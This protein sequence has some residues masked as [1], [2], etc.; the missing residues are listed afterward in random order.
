MEILMAAFTAL[1]LGVENDKDSEPKAKPTPEQQAVAAL[2]KLGAKVHYRKRFYFEVPAKDKEK[3]IA[4]VSIE[5][6]WKGGDEGTRY[7]HVIRVAATE[8]ATDGHGPSLQVL[9]YRLIGHLIL[10]RMPNEGVREALESLA[11]M[12][13]FYQTRLQNPEALKLP[14]ATLTGRVGPVMLRPEFEFEEASE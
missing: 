10:D 4:L 5:E 11:S 13:Q 7:D 1:A 2:E 12:C 6:N 8:D 14:T 9:P 3:P